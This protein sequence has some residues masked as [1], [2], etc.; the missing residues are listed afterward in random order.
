VQDNG[1]GAS[2]E[3]QQNLLRPFTQ[4]NQAHFKGSGLGLSIV[5]RTTEKK[6]RRKINP[7]QF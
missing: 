5:R 2:T 7:L 1:S 4:L 6:R 3:D